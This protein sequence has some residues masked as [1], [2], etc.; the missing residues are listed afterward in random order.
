MQVGQAYLFL[1]YERNVITFTHVKKSA[2]W[3]HT[4]GGKF[5]KALPGPF[6]NFPLT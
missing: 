2:Y 4:S 1:A 3:R 5:L 6:K